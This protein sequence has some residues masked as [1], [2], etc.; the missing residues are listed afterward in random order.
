MAAPVPS[1]SNWALPLVPPPAAA[2]EDDHAGGQLHI[3]IAAA[4]RDHRRHQ[5]HDGRVP[6]RGGNAL[7][8]IESSVRRCVVVWTSTIGL[9]PETVTV[10]S[11]VPTLQVG[12]QVET[13][14]AGSSS[15]SRLDRGE[16]RQREGDGIGAGPQVDDSVL[17]VS[18]GDRRTDLLNQCGLAASTVTPGSTAPDVSL[19]TPVMD[20]LGVRRRGDHHKA[21]HDE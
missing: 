9:S 7:D 6:A 18:I 20:A 11:S 10:S 14:S 3:G 12:V 19:T 1:P 13:K 5:Q 4:G 16:P 2:A 17:P 21:S 15:P 8:Q